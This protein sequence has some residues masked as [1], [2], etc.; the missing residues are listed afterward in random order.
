[1]EMVWRGNRRSRHTA[2]TRAIQLELGGG[3]VRM[4]TRVC[5][6]AQALSHAYLK[7]AES[8]LSAFRAC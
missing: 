1:M 8:S 3:I 4:G 5:P 2:A 6:L 7:M